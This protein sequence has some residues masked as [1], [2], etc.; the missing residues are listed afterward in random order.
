MIIRDSEG[1]WLGGYYG[2]LSVSN[3]LEAEMHAIFVGVE[4][5]KSRII[6]GARV[7]T[8]SMLAFSL[9]QNQK[10]SGHPMMSLIEDVKTLLKELNSIVQHTFRE[11]NKCAD[12][13][14]KMGASQE[15][16]FVYLIEPTPTLVP[17]IKADE[18]GVSYIRS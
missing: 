17:L 3:S 4:V 8:D 12:F 16:P 2:S 10:E 11:G 18:E 15:L 14:A 1:K 6:K 7:E 9:I 5:L 13:L